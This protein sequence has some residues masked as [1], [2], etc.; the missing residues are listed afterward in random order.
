MKASV[1]ALVA[2]VFALFSAAA[3]AG[4]YEVQLCA[5][6]QA[7]GFVAHNDNAAVLDHGVRVPAGRK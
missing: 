1:F 7:T 4:T 3:H 6:P 5:D 2:L